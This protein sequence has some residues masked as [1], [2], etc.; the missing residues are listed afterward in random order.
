MPGTLNGCSFT[1]VNEIANTISIES[2]PNPFHADLT[3]SVAEAP[4]EDCTIQILDQSSRSLMLQN[5]KPSDW[6]ENSIKL[7]GLETLSV[8]VYFIEIKLNGVSATKKMTKF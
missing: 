8:G 6:T 1:D 4:N 7:I 5:I 2:F 3:L